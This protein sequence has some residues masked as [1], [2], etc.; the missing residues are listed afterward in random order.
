MCID[1]EDINEMTE[2]CN[3]Y[4]IDVIDENQGV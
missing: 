2:I 3:K 1:K 4:G